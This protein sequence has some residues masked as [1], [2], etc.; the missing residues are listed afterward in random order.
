MAEPLDE[1]EVK[2]LSEFYKQGWISN[3][4]RPMMAWSY[5][6]IC[7]FDFLIAPIGFPILSTFLGIETIIWKPL[8]L[9]GGG[10]YHLAMG[11][12]VGVTSWSRGNLNLKMAE[13]IPMPMENNAPDELEY[14]EDELEPPPERKR[15][16]R[17]SR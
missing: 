5:M 3:K 16:G 2:E 7:L 13:R 1:F 15:R 6:I 4:W 12:I 8:T 17:S 14:E 11:A 10:L 9:E